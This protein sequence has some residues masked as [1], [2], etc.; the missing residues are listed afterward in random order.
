MNC[1]ITG[2]NGFLGRN[3]VELLIFIEIKIKMKFY[4]LWF[5]ERTLLSKKSKN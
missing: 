2:A 3:I 4:Y 1:L 5:I